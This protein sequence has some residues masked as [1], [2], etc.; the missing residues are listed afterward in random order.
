MQIV[1]VAD[2]RWIDF[3]YTHMDLNVLVNTLCLFHLSG[4]PRI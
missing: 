3:V 4:A 1:H 2:S